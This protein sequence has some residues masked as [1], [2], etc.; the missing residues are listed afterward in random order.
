MW[1][2]GW[3]SGFFFFY[4][5]AL[6]QEVPGRFGEA[7][8]HQQLEVV[9]TSRATRGWTCTSSDEVA[10]GRDST[11]RAALHAQKAFDVDCKIATR[12]L[13]PALARH[14]E[15]QQANTTSSGTKNSCEDLQ[16]MAMKLWRLVRGVRMKENTLQR[17]KDFLAHKREAHDYMGPSLDSLRPVPPAAISPMVTSL[18]FAVSCLVRCFQQRKLEIMKTNHD[19][20]QPFGKNI[21][22]DDNDNADA[23]ERNL[24]KLWQYAREAVAKDL[25]HVDNWRW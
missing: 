21:Q 18:A 9:V 11:S 7:C 10:S 20:S 22:Q 12:D 14:C 3:G 13:L 16:Q 24:R 19:F 25:N 1:R 23:L 17:Q 2:K 5:N 8:S 6:P 15:Q 4:S